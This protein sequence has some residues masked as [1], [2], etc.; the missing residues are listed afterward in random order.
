MQRIILP[1]WLLL[2]AGLLLP[3]SSQAD[4]VLAA[5]HRRDRNPLLS[6]WTLQ[7][8]PGYPTV[9]TN[10]FAVTST[11]CWAMTNGSSAYRYDLTKEQGEQ[12]RD[13][14][15]RLRLDV[16]MRGQFVATNTLPAVNFSGALLDLGDGGS[17][18][19]LNMG[20][21]V[22]AFGIT[23]FGVK[24]VSAPPGQDISFGR[25]NEGIGPFTNIVEL[26]AS[27]NGVISLYVNGVYRTNYW[28]NVGDINSTN[29]HLRIFH[30]PSPAFPSWEV[31]YSRI[32]LEIFQPGGRAQAALDLPLNG[33]AYDRSVNVLHP[34]VVGA[35]PTDPAVLPGRGYAF[36]GN[37][38]LHLP[39]TPVLEPGHDF[40]F[41][42]RV[43][44]RVRN[45]KTV[46]VFDNPAFVDTTSFTTNAE[47]DN[48][49]AS[50]QSLGHSVIP[51]TELDASIAWAEATSG[52]LLLPELETPEAAAGDLAGAIAG[53][54]TETALR[55][56]VR[57]GGLL[58][59]NGSHNLTRGNRDTD[60]LNLVFGYSLSGFPTQGSYILNPAQAEGT[61]FAG[62]P[63]IVPALSGSRSL[64]INSLPPRSRSIYT[65][66]A[67]QTLLAVIPEGRGRIVFLGWDWFDGAPIGSLD[68]GWIDMLDRAVLQSVPALAVFDNPAFV[69]TAG[70]TGS[71][72]D[73]IQASLEW[74]GRSV[75]AL[76]NLD[77]AIDAAG[78]LLIPELETGDLAAAIAGTGA[79]S[80][81]RD[82]VRNGGRLI[83]NGSHHPVAGNRDTALLNLLFGYGLS[84]AITT[85]TCTINEGQAAGT[86]FDGAQPTLPANEGSRALTVASLPSGARGIYTN[87]SNQTILALIPEGDGEIVYL[88]Y[89]WFDAAPRG[90]QDNGWID[91][92]N[93]AVQDMAPSHVGSFFAK[94]SGSE[95]FLFDTRSSTS[96]NMGL[97][98][99]AGAPAGERVD[100]TTGTDL[101]LPFNHTTIITMRFKD[102]LVDIFRNGQ[103]WTSG[104]F[105]TRHTLADTPGDWFFGYGFEG[106]LSDVKI[107]TG[108]L[109]DATIRWRTTTS[110]PDELA[111]D[112]RDKPGPEDLIAGSVHAATGAFIK[113]IPALKVQ[114]RGTLAV[115]LLYNSKQPAR[116]EL[117][118]GW[119]HSF[120]IKLR[121]IIPGVRVT[122]DE[123]SGELYDFFSEGSGAPYVPFSQNAQYDQLTSRSS[124]RYEFVGPPQGWTY[125][126]INSW[127]LV[128]PDGTRYDFDTYGLLTRVSDHLGNSITF[129]RDPLNPA[130]ILYLLDDVNQLI[131]FGYDQA[132]G[133]LD[134]LGDRSGRRVQFDYQGDH[135][136]RVYDPIQTAVARHD[137]TPPFVVTV[138]TPVTVTVTNTAP[139]GQVRY[140][141]I[142]QALFHPSA[143]GPI[144]L[145]SPGGTTA[146]LEPYGFNLRTDAF[147][148]E[149]PQGTWTLT[150]AGAG[151]LGPCYAYASFSM[152]VL[153]QDRGLGGVNFVEFDYLGST[154]QAALANGTNQLFY[155]TFSG[156]RVFSLD[157]GRPESAWHLF[158]YID[159][160]DGTSR[161][162]HYDRT[163][164]PT[165]Y[166]YDRLGHLLQKQDPRGGLIAYTYDPITGNRTSVTDQ[167]GRRTY[168]EYD[169]FGQVVAMRNPRGRVTRFAYA[170]QDNGISQ[171]TV[172]NPAGNLVGVTDVSG[173]K[174]SHFGYDAGNNLI[175]IT[176]A[177]GQVHRIEFTGLDPS[178]SVN[179]DGAQVDLAYA[180]GQVVGAAAAGE[181]YTFD[182]DLAGR[183]IASTDAEGNQTTVRYNLN[184]SVAERRNALGDSEFFEYNS[185][186]LRTLHRNRRGFVTRYAY[187]GNGNLIA[188]TNAL[189]Q[190]F[191]FEYDGEDRLIHEIDPAGH[192]KSYAYDAMGLL[193][194]RSN[195]LDRV[196]RFAYDPTGS[197]IATTNALLGVDRAVYQYNNLRTITL[198]AS[199]NAT[200]VQYDDYGRPASRQDALGRQVTYSYDD[201]GRLDEVVQA[202]PQGDRIAR[203][204]YGPDD[205]L[206]Q[207]EL[208]SDGDPVRYR[209]GFDPL[210]RVTNV[211]TTGGRT[212]SFAYDN[213]GEL[214]GLTLPSGKGMAF[215][216]DPAGRLSRTAYL[217]NGV[218]R[219]TIPSLEFDYDPNGN[220]TSVGEDDDG[221]TN[222]PPNNVIRRAYDALD[223]MQFEQ[224]PDA[225]AA[226]FFYN[227]VG[228]VSTIIY[229]DSFEVTY[230]YDAARRVTHVRA[231]EPGGPERV[232]LYTY[233]EL[234]QVTFVSFPNGATRILTYDS[235]GHMTSLE[236][237]DAS[238]DTIA[239][240]L[241]AYDPLNRIAPRRLTPA[242]AAPAVTNGVTYT[243]DDANR[244][245]HINGAASV[246]YDADGNVTGGPVNGIPDTFAWDHRNNLVSAPGD[247][248]ATAGP[249]TF[250]YDVEDKLIGW[251]I[252]EQGQS[253]F[254][255]V[256]TAAGAQILLQHHPDGSVT[257][258]VHGVGL[259]YEERNGNVQV[260]HYDHAGNTIA[261]TDAGGQVSGRIEYD[262]YGRI[263]QK[264]GATD[265]VF[266]FGGLFGVVT[267]PNGL[268]NMRYRWYHPELGRFLSEDSH[269]GTIGQMLS[270]NRYVYGLNSPYNHIDPE[271]ELPVILV[272]ILVGAGIGAAG[273]HL[274]WKLYL[275]ALVQASRPLPNLPN[276]ELPA[277]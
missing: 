30:Q 187:D 38:Y 241:Y 102:G 5:A 49:Q 179:K 24:T 164:A 55:D 230:E 58:I 269:L 8:A 82:F 41:T 173:N 96:T 245:T 260:H 11:R 104:Q 228:L 270:L 97:R 115:S 159:D 253:R 195:Q 276:Y 158:S 145:T 111:L 75:T 65:N 27:Q 133:M 172:F 110:A 277:F 227:N 262:P 32:D 39:D 69:D 25:V 263:I 7:G 210:N 202:D 9:V 56:F 47:S 87:A 271:G 92:L 43:T 20:L 257:R 190:V 94:N 175:A 169:P 183:M 26:V 221:N 124:Y 247:H 238:G 42:A 239:A 81:L 3:A 44:P 100:L 132:T 170:N 211:A 184:D 86:R 259:I 23:N 125:S 68:S 160:P 264:S 272:G 222:T 233:N 186:G 261:L 146:T 220:L 66:A 199:G 194:A 33:D 181:S 48:I 243:Y 70:G 57:N 161:T 121:D 268:C 192:S 203:N 53:T 256:Q 226:L 185:R 206:E 252:P 223:R 118:V 248:V 151:A 71:E 232:T 165:A 229:P 136:K 31:C 171:S 21:V 142:T 204:V 166:R 162:F 249:V 141:L 153:D 234:D 90:T 216:Y 135:L 35:Q 156:G 107:F 235:A 108:A 112:I 167:I 84:G 193:L 267:A 99:L 149:N 103:P 4:S 45:R 46:A 74:L 19:E 114:G 67:L 214:S 22:G 6:G 52:I 131:Y 40:T 122:V 51:V 217:L 2:T 12:A 73:N 76:T 88:G 77:A 148:G 128:K 89:D 236:D 154:L 265:T 79:E 117:G 95:F 18:F 155:V 17:R 127:H 50:L 137:A 123:P 64:A 147:A 197:Q 212:M 101:L 182:Y 168:F 196:T 116:A 61:R 60:L 37:D 126:V 13:F 174:E 93:R 224:K 176:N 62:G 144:T 59:M 237:R 113:E 130:R 16:A 83:L 143:C 138:N 10:V 98:V 178:A 109:S 129:Q 139:V 273:E 36:D 231:R 254:F 150:L 63:T 244:L 29:A 213:Q 105:P 180:N 242:P 205:V 189:N 28:G 14:G 188:L 177:D 201:L 140:D 275:E 120:D 246:T 134:S 215:R 240:H 80:A 106:V 225:T 209:F 15:W 85:N 91:I 258:Y 207:V 274:H 78:T 198:D 163:G 152:F 157:D 34:V 251:N 266:K 219:T 218:P 208:I 1:L 54:A 255:T 250:Q 72:S 200:T 191:R 119:R